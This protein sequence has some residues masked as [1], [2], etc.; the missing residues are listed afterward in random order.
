MANITLAVNSYISFKYNENDLLG[1]IVSVG[2]DKINIKLPT[3]CIIEANKDIE[4]V[5]VLSAEDYNSKVKDLIKVLSENIGI[6]DMDKELE[7]LKTELETL[8]ASLEKLTKENES[9]TKSKNEAESKLK[10]IEFARLGESRFVELKDLDYADKVDE[11]P[12]KAKKAL[13]ELNDVQWNTVFN[14]AKAFKKATDQVTTSLKKTTDQTVTS[15]PKTTEQTVTATEKE[16]K[17]TKVE[18]D[19]KDETKVIV[20]KD[21]NEMTLAKILSKRTNK[22]SK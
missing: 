2:E 4:S 15:E 21:A 13:A 7:Q 19:T 18:S 9:L 6:K 16:V 22:K 11:D 14:G 12:I 5:E 3:G 17:E 10:D 8:K 20:D 1:Q